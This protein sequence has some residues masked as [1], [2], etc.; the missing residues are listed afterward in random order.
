[1]EAIHKLV[2]FF[3]NK[4]P[5]WY[6]WYKLL[7]ALTVDEVWMLEFFVLASCAMWWFLSSDF[8]TV[9]KDWTKMHLF[10]ISLQVL[11]SLPLL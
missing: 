1:M 11:C 6:D 3:N 4:L 8:I 9:P 10:N 2:D 5:V 7:Q